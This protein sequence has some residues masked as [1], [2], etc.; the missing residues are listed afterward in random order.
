MGGGKD[1]T[2][3]ARP[4]LS[5]YTAAKGVIHPREADEISE[6]AKPHCWP[7]KRLRM[8]HVLDSQ[9]PHYTTDSAGDGRRM[10]ITRDSFASVTLIL[11]Q[12]RNGII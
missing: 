12:G 7:G 8:L 6:L 2:M 5:T 4:R 3:Q 11:C 1:G 10:R 9:P